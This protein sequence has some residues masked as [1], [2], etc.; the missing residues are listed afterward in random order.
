[1]ERCAAKGSIF[2][3]WLHFLILTLGHPLQFAQPNKFRHSTRTIGSLLEQIN[4]TD[5]N[6]GGCEEAPGRA[7]ACAGRPG[8]YPSRE[9]APAAREAHQRC[10]QD[11]AERL[12]HVDTGPASVWASV[13]PLRGC[14]STMLTCIVLYRTLLGCEI[15]HLC[16]SIIVENVACTNSGVED[17]LNSRWGTAAT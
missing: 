13:S 3:K 1:V 10:A 9:A 8:G 2:G 6:H 12:L 15:P 14:N 11:G 17:P 5:D 16:K 4:P 7:G